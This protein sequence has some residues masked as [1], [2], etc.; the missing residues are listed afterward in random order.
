E[1]LAQHLRERRGVALAIVERAG[2]D[3][4]RAVR[5]EANPA[6]LLVGRGRHL[7]IAA[8]ADAAQL[9]AL[10]ALAPARRKS[11]PVP[12]LQPLFHDSGEIAA[13][14]GRARRRL[15]R[16]LARPDLVATAEL[17]AVDAGLGRRHVDDALHEI[18]AFGPAGA[19]IGADEGGVGQ[20]A[21]DRG[22]DQRR[23]I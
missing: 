1:L 22:L 3:R 4:H 2:E 9:A 5:F 8:D 15:V 6:H 16:Q 17:D 13:V 14:I 21:L 12:A 23:A 19:A 20:H 7:E 10:P 11:L 18:I